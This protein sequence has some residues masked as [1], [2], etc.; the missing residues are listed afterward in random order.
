MLMPLLSLQIT[1]SSLSKE[2]DH[3]KYLSQRLQTWHLGK[4]DSLV[5][6]GRAIQHQLAQNPR[7][8]PGKDNSSQSFA[9]L[10]LGGKTHHALRLLTEEGQG[11]ILPVIQPFDKWN[12]AAGTV[13][14]A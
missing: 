8:L 13:L 4:L 12:P 7:N 5:Q 2:K 14:E 11:S 6:E 10:I 3:C 9:K 1:P